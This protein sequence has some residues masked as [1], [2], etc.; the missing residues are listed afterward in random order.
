MKKSAILP[1]LC[2]VTT[3]DQ[4]KVN[5]GFRNL[6]TNLESVWSL[7]KTQSQIKVT[8]YQ[9]GLKEKAQGAM[10]SSTSQDEAEAGS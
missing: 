10:V 9:S 5:R 7:F 3:V 4:S 2:A 1:P 6:V 8:T